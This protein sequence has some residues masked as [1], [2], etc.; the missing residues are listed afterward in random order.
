MEYLLFGIALIYFVL[1][2]NNLEIDIMSFAL[3]YS[4][5][6]ISFSF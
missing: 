2:L 5:L 3:L 6:I 4:Y 1:M